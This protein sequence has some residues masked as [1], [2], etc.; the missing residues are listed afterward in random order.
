MNEFG[1][2]EVEFTKGS[3]YIMSNKSNNKVYYPAQPTGQYMEN[4]EDDN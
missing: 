3:S 1:D 4:T 2:N